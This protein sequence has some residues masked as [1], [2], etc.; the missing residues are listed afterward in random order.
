MGG[1]TVHLFRGGLFKNLF[2]LRTR[3]QGKGAH[4]KTK[5]KQNAPK[6]GAGEG[7]YLFWMQYYAN[8]KLQDHTRPKK[9]KNHSLRGIRIVQIEKARAGSPTRETER[10]Q[11]ASAR[12]KQSSSRFRTGVSSYS[13]FK[14]CAETEGCHIRYQPWRVKISEESSGVG[15]SLQGSDVE[16]LPR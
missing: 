10:S 11:S 1:K 9:K 6:T 7:A 13:A 3:R 12:R 14:K 15:A 2:F 4:I 5:K 16:L 8:D